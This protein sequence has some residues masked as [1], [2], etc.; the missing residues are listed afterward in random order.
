MRLGYLVKIFRIIVIFRVVFDSL[1]QEFP[2]N[3]SF[4]YLR[5]RSNAAG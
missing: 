5:G 3:A 4:K 1:S 2:T